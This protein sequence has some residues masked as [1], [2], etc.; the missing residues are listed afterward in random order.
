MYSITKTFDSSGNLLQNISILP[1]EKLIKTLDV[2]F[3]PTHPNAKIPTRATPGSLGYD[4]YSA[5]FYKIGPFE[6]V[7][8]N[9]GLKMQLPE[10]YGAILKPRSGLAVKNKID[11]FAGVIDND[12]CLEWQV[13][14][15][16]FNVLGWLNNLIN[17]KMNFGLPVPGELSI[18]PG[19]RIGQ[20]I[21]I[22]QFDI[23]F[24]QAKEISNINRTGGFGSTGK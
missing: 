8:I 7:L 9:T 24:K 16:N 14:L 12:F 19:D 21:I 1:E 2:N 18:N 15:T 22:P 11:L 4:L 20:M 17:K 10:G 3:V 6:T 5:D 23:N 13:V